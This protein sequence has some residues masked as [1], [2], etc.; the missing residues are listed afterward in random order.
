MNGNSNRQKVARLP[1]MA[2]SN[3]I[4][5]VVVNDIANASC[6]LINEATREVCEN[7]FFMDSTRSLAAVAVFVSKRTQ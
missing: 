2:Q 4:K 3:L 1:H 5:E 6:Q 7:L